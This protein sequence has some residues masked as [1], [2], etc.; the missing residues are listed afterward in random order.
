MKLSVS[1][2]AWGPEHD[3]EMYEFLAANGYAG[4]EIAPTRVFENQPYERITEARQ[5]ASE[6]TAKHGLHVCSMQSLWYGRDEMIFG[7]DGERGFL[8][9]YTEKAAK[10]AEAIGCK[11]LVLG[12]P[13]NRAIEDMS[14]LPTAVDFFS[15]I[16]DCAE[17]H[18]CVIALE[19]NPADY[20]TNFINTTK[21]AADM[22]REINRKGFK[23]NLDLGTVIANG[24][25]IEAVSSY[26][27]IISHVHISEP[28]LKP[29]GDRDI[30]RRLV[31]ILN[32]AGYNNYVSIETANT[33][34][35]EDIKNAALYIREVFK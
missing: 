2:I 11:N 31:A 15:R 28:F 9:E 19:A 26:V 23:I 1:N 27:D 24:E 20:G 21:Q 10:F 3:D 13:K 8:I 30:H 6:L 17:H 25:G 12:S 35:I 18:N 16:A 34:S 4:L 32:D 7:S 29:L 5:F 33:K 22:C 14:Q